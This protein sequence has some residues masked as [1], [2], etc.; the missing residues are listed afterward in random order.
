MPSLKHMKS[1]FKREKTPVVQRPPPVDAISQIDA[2]AARSAPQQIPPNPKERPQIPVQQITAE[3]IRDLRELIRHRYSLD[4]E[5]WRQSKVKSFKR[6]RL[7]EN[8]RRSDATLEHIRRILVDWDRREYFASDVEH[9]K[10]ID[11]KTRLLKGV[12]ANWAQ[13]PPWEFV[14]HGSDPYSG[15]WEKHGRAI[16]VPA[17]TAYQTQRSNGLEGTAITSQQTPL[18]SAHRG[19]RHTGEVLTPSHSAS[20]P[21]SSSQRPTPDYSSFLSATRQPKNRRPPPIEDARSPTWRVPTPFDGNGTPLLMSP[22]PNTGSRR[23]TWDDSERRVTGP[24]WQH[25]PLEHD[26]Q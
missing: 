8:M 18:R 7:E 4:I 23:A 16:D 24:Q 19:L 21:I 12:K 15:P 6:R 13:N 1:F 5:I 20:R 10:F 3:Q 25:E 11:I 22:G 14:H 17:A 26:G 2:I 9:L